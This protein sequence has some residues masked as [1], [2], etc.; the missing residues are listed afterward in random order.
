MHTL[1]P[2]ALLL[3]L[4]LAMGLAVAVAKDAAGASSRCSFAG[5][6]VFS[7]EAPGPAELPFCVQHRCV[8]TRA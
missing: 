3:P 1:S 7:D 5:E 2:P 4:L 8:C 6:F